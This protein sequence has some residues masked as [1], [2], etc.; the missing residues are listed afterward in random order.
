M[1]LLFLSPAAN[2]GGA[3]RCMLDYAASLL[4][5]A[6]GAEI[7]LLVA[8]DGPL[9]QEASSLGV[10]VLRLGFGNHLAEVG[11]S[12][13]RWYGSGAL[14][15]FSERA[16]RASADVANY[17]FQL[18]T[19][20]R[21]FSPS[22]V[23]SNGL[24]MH[25]LAAAARN[26]APLV[27]HLHDFIGE[28]PVISRALRACAWRANAFIANSNAVAADASRFL[29]RLASNVIYN[30][31]DTDFFSPT[32]AIANL[33]ALA[34]CDPCESQTVRVGLIATYAR[35]KGHDVFL[36]AVRL[37]RSRLSAAD[38]RFYIIGGPIDETAA[39]QYSEGELR[40]L[41]DRFG[42]AESV[43][44]VPF[45][46]RVDEV[47]RALD[48]VV[49]ASSRPEPFGR[50]IVEGMAA[51]KAVVACREGGAAELFSDGV[52]AIGVRPRDPEAMAEAIVGLVRN[53]SRRDVLGRTGRAAATQRFARKRLA[54]QLLRV[55]ERAG[56]GAFAAHG[57]APNEAKA[58]SSSRS[59]ENH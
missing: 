41:I 40:A 57:A 17:V 35:W 28:R 1:R 39:S 4:S 47:Y 37:V 58:P 48:I 7:G 33:D 31:I 43:R 8:A 12:A 24:K 13:L 55:Y 3:E 49:H 11:D 27:W 45:Q 36:E 20:I 5:R 34:G 16:L 50:T 29:P 53:P 42:L 56:V 25:L 32:G 26:G 21:S 54:D 6:P 51:G 19:A 46:N 52:E 9:V 30:A 14:R 38:V 59:A 2:L 22:V 18:R 10:R 15:G 23:H 44:V